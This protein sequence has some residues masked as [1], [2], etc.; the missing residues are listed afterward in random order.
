MLRHNRITVNLHSKLLYS[1][2]KK[3]AQKKELTLSGII[4]KIVIAILRSDVTDTLF[5]E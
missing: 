4:Q 3:L 5:L 1:D 2:L